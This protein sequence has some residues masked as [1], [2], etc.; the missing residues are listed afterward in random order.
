M[1]QLYQFLMI[2][3]GFALRVSFVVNVVPAKKLKF[4]SFDDL[5]QFGS[6]CWKRAFFIQARLYP[7]EVSYHGTSN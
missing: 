1:G 3:E 4:W 7:T 2:G 6:A 5:L